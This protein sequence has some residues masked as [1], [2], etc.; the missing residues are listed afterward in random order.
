MRKLVLVL[1][2]SACVERAVEMKIEIPNPM[3]AIASFDTSCLTAVEVYVDGANY[4]ADPNDFLHKCFTIDSSPAGYAQV[5]DALRGKVTLPVPASG[6]RHVEMFGFAGS[7]ADIEAANTGLIPDLLFLSNTP[8]IGQD[9]IDM[10]IIPNLSC[11]SSRVSVR[12]VD[13]MTLVS[14]PA[15]TSADCAAAAVPDGPRTGAWTATVLMGPVD[16]HLDWWGGIT[17][18]NSINSV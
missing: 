5:A 11:K 10:Q 15:P 2:S 9:T 7:C 1:L 3:L 17:G 8:Y 12:L 4:P 14:K 16:K 18:A 13:L 6:L